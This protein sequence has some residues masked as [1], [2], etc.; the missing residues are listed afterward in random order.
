MRT[1]ARFWQSPCPLEHEAPSLAGY[2]GP[3]L[4][5]FEHPDIQAREG[6][7]VYGILTHTFSG[8][9]VE[10]LSI[11]CFTRGLGT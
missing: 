6:S 10:R 5:K 3:S 2:I 8:S 1:L 9:Q 7:V 11:G 4:I